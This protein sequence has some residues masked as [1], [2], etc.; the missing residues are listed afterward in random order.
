MKRIFAILSCIFVAFTILAQKDVTKFLGIPVDGSKS[1]MIRKLKT[2]GFTY[3][4]SGEVDGLKGK[5]NGV[6][7]NLFISTE[8]GK[9]ARIM[10][11]DDDIMGETDIKIRFN[12]LCQQFNNNGKYIG[13]QDFTIPEEEDISY[14]MAVNDKRYEALFYQ[15]PEGETVEQ[16]KSKLIAHIISKYTPEEIQNFS[17]EDK[18]KVFFDSMSILYGSLYNKPVWFMIS[19]QYGKYYITMF[20][21]NE[22]NRA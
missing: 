14:K 21:D 7:V 1:E 13:L 22:Y 5:F 2:K 19:E 17:E 8:N 20:Y 6:N 15:I 12:R 11:C 10:V 3:H 16:M 9:V 4:K 18:E